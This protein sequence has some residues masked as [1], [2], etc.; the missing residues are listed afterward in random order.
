MPPVPHAARRRRSPRGSFRSSARVPGPPLPAHRRWPSSF[1]LV[2]DLDG[3]V[4]GLH[5][6][7]RRR[8][9]ASTGPSSATTAWPRRRSPPPGWSVGWRRVA[10]D[11]PARQIRRRRPGRGVELLA[12][13]VDPRLQGRG[14][15]GRLVDAFLDRVRC[16]GRDAR[17]TSWSAAANVPAIALYRRAGFAPATSSS[18]MPAPRRSLMQWDR[19]LRR[20][21]GP[22]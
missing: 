12:V 3:R 13:A 1:L 6:R 14:T 10:R 19:G 17:P 4:V 15:G 22:G 21:T 16:D 2:A 8:A 5:R 7:H 18:S 20:M 9:V 11:P